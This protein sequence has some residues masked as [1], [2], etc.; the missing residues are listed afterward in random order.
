MILSAAVDI[1]ILN[2]GY[3][4]EKVNKDWHYLQQRVNYEFIT[5]CKIAVA[6]ILMYSAMTFSSAVGVNYWYWKSIHYMRAS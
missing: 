5:V 3:D 2:T 6:T 1:N 4:R